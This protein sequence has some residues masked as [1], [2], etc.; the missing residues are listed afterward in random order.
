MDKIKKVIGIVVNPRKDNINPILTS[1]STWA[2]KQSD[3]IQFLLC[4]FNSPYVKND[5]ACLEPSEEKDLLKKSELTI[6]LG[7]DGTLLRTVNK[8]NDTSIHVLGVNLGGLGFLANTPPD[9]LIDH[10]E[11]YLQGNYVVDERSMLTCT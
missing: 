2:K 8:L 1:F 6:T 11:N 4:T 7:G 10:V 5:F 3:E 9:K